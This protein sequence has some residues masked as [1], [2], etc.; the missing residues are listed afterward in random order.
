M[1][2]LNSAVKVPN[3]P[4]QSA[5]LRGYAGQLGRLVWRF[6]LAV[7]KALIQYRE[8]VLDMQLVQER[9]ANVAMEMFAC[10]CTLSRLDSELQA[11]GNNGGTPPAQ[12]QAAELFL[13]QSIRRMRQNLAGLV[14]NDDRQVLA[15]AD[16]VLGKTRASARNGT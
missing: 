2:R 16:A 9:I 4:V 7:N 3:V 13:T 8:P 15:T 1:N 11:T 6:N 10:A 5:A 14:D 12:R